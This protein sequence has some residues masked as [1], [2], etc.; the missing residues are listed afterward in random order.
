M[1][2]PGASWRLLRHSKPWMPRS[3]CCICHAKCL[4]VVSKHDDST[5]KT[6]HFKGKHNHLVRSIDSDGDKQYTI[7]VRIW[8]L[9]H[10]LERSWWMEGWPST[11]GGLGRQIRDWHQANC[12]CQERCHRNLMLPGWVSLAMLLVLTPS[13][14]LQ[15]PSFRQLC[16]VFPPKKITSKDQS[17]SQFFVGRTSILYIHHLSPSTR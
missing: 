9:E 10:G 5:K 1:P 14:H 3:S 15:T 17:P 12:S 8:E 16:R 11:S 6:W 2:E 4:V 13:G 7:Q